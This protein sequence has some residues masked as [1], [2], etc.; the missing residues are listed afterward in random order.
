MI[1]T[2]ETNPLILWP[3]FIIQ[4][5]ALK[6]Y[7]L[8]K[9]QHQCQVPI[10]PICPL[11]ASASSNSLLKGNIS[12]LAWLDKQSCN[13]VIYVSLGSIA[14]MDVKELIEFAWG[15]V[16]SQQPFLWVV[17]LDSVCGAKWIEVLPESFKKNIS[18]RG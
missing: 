17:R 9:I 15:L 1:I 7:Y 5:T 13:S 6:I 12:C 4:L 14:L 18:E 8:T 11:H 2:H 16:N 10:F 3:S